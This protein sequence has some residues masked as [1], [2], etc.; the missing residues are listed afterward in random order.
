MI[1]AKN[2]NK[3]KLQLFV[4]TVL[5][6]SGIGAR[7]QEA[8]VVHELEPL[9][10]KNCAAC[11]GP[12]TQTA[13]INL[14]SLIREAPLVK[15]LETWRRV[16]SALEVGKMP[17]PGAP[18]PTVAAR[19][20]MLD[21]LRNDIENFDFS[22]IDNPGFELM[23]RLT[24]TEYDNTIRDLFGVRLDVTERFPVELIGNSG[25]ENSSNTLFLQSS[26]MER[27]IGAAQTIV[28]LS[29]IHI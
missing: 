27:Y 1:G 18:Q 11:H 19:A 22:T 24:H 25:F 10:A 6:M 26:L 9:L 3:V 12:E 16:I 2:S 20:R 14:T 4:V 7:G 15:N 29:L 17:P 13:G 5:L 21:L 28:D 8:E 23:R